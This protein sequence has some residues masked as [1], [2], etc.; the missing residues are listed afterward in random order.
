MKL[1][2][3]LVL[4]LATKAA[5][6]AQTAKWTTPVSSPSPFVGVTAKPTPIAA[7]PQAVLCFQDAALPI[8][9]GQDLTMTAGNTLSIGISNGA[10]DPITGPKGPW[11]ATV[12][13]NVN[14]VKFSGLPVDQT[15]GLVVQ[16]QIVGVQSLTIQLVGTPQYL[17][18]VQTVTSQ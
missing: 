15:N 12:T 4:L 13:L 9:C 8:V 7:M 10:P 1:F 14:G 11:P 18:A 17:G 5:A 6:V 16:R 3:T 2:M